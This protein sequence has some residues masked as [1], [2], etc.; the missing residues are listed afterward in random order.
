VAHGECETAGKDVVH[1]ATR[2]GDHG[3]LGSSWM[4]QANFV[5]GDWIAAD[6]G[7]T[8]D[9]TNPAT[10]EVIGTVPACGEAETMRAIDAATAAFPEACG[11]GP[12]DARGAF[13]EAA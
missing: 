13:V 8:I 2:G 10:G 11:N 4:K 9:V 3:R 5:A 1:T 12:D 7:K 6:S